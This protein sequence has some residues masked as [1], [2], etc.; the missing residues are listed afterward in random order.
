MRCPSCARHS[1]PAASFDADLLTL[2]LLWSTAPSAPHSACVASMNSG[3]SGAAGGSVLNSKN[4]HSHPTDLLS[5]CL[6]RLISLC[7]AGTATPDNPSHSHSCDP[8]Y[9]FHYSTRHPL[10]RCLGAMNA[11]P[12][13]QLCF[14]VSTAA[15]A[16]GLLVILLKG[17]CVGAAGDLPVSSHQATLSCA[18][19]CRRS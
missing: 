12:K 18:D 11:L 1:S 13:S 6:H 19:S 5:V 17:Y 16:V 7:D 4:K 8:L 10:S 2:S 3:Y 15:A 14:R 9:E